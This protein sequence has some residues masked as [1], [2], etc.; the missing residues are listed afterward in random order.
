MKGWET[1]PNAE[2]LRWMDKYIRPGRLLDLGAGKGWY[3]LHAD[4]LGCEVHAVDQNS[5]F[6]HEGVKQITQSLENPLAFPDNHFGNVLAWDI[7]EHVEKEEQ[8]LAEIVRVLQSD[9]VLLLSVPHGNDEILARRHLTYCHF[10][11]R[12]HRREYLPDGLRAKCE[13]QGLKC[14][15]LSLTGGRM[16]PFLICDFIRNGLVRS[17]VS[18]GIRAGSRLRLIDAGDCHADLFAVFC[19]R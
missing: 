10:K 7:L 15:E 16:Y 11:D 17:L 14:V 6:S 5:Q 19:L 2:K 18:L 3:S 1:S 9:G 4:K 13:R 8:L 12:S